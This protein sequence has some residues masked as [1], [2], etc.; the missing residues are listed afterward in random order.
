MTSFAHIVTA[1]TACAPGFRIRAAAIDETG[2][3][4]LETVP[5]VGLADTVELDMDT[6]EVERELVAAY[7]DPDDGSVRP[8]G[9][10]VV[11]GWRAARVLAPGDAEDARDAEL[12][13]QLLEEFRAREIVDRWAEES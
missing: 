5:V 2:D 6:G 10:L 7:L 11:E 13:A 1:V 4:T 12:A 3:V 9:D 8:F